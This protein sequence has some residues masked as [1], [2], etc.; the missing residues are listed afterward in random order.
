MRMLSSVSR[1]TLDLIRLSMQWVP[2]A[3][4]PGVQQLGCENDHSSPF[5]A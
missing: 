5:G 3:L 1:P 2:K 4:Y